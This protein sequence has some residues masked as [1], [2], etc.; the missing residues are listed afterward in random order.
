MYSANKLLA[1]LSGLF[2][3]TACKN[4]M[5]EKT[6]WVNSAKVDCVGVGPMQ[7]YQIKESEEDP[8]MF[9]YQQI[10]GFD[11]QPGYIYRLKVQVESLDIEET[12]A[13]KS[14]LEYT[15]VEVLSK[16]VD[17]VSAIN[18]IWKLTELNGSEIDATAQ[19]GELPNMELNTRNETVL[20]FDGC[21]NYRGKIE[22]VTDKELVFGPLLST[23]KLCPDMTLPNQLGPTLSTVRAYKKDGLELQ[24]FDATGSLVCRFKKID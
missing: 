4:N 2:L 16:E 15:L 20:G 21:N 5:T 24:L 11:F 23:R 17:P 14:N 6:L 19:T 18:D 7:C 12:L 10:D 13:D 1:L 22:K 9:F 8:W 3:F